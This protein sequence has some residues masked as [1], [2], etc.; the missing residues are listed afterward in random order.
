[1]LKNEIRILL[2]KFN[3]DLDPELDEQQLVDAIVIERLVRAAGVSKQDTVLEVGA[4]CGNITMALAEAAGRV[5]VVEKKEKFFPILEER[6]APFDNV[7]LIHGDALQIR[8]PPLTKVVSNLPYSICEAMLRRLTR[9]RFEKASLIVPESF[10]DTVTSEPGDRHY[11]RLTLV[12]S[13]FFEILKIGDLEQGSYYPP[14]GVTTRLIT[15]EPHEAEDYGQELLRQLVLREKMKLK[16]ALRESLIAASRR[17]PGPS[18][19]REAKEFIASMGLDNSLLDRRMA[20]T[21]LS[22]LESVLKRFT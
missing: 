6:T 20:R 10:A 14:P 16:N 5:L 2:K 4:G 12:A 22:D 11:S 1:L 17:F 7:D 18:T 9:L 13:A 3:I 19:K 15:L 21:S 8:F